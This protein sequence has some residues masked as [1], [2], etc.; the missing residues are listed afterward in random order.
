MIR[1]DKKL[2]KKIAKERIEI[3]LERAHKFKEKDISL[4]R[5]YV[6]LAMKISS[7]YRVQIPPEFRNTFCR[8]CYTPFGA[9]TVKIRLNHGTK[10]IR[11]MSCGFARRIQYRNKR[12]F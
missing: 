10:L 5:R 12:T 9:E 1:R 3:L 11:C 6:E 4:A 8:K 7:K 2:E